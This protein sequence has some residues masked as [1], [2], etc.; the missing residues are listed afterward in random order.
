MN[1]GLLDTDVKKFGEL[2]VRAN[3]IQLQHMANALFDE[4]QRRLVRER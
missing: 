3:D 4:Q 2:L 1:E